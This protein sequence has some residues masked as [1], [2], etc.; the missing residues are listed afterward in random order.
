M[1]VAALGSRV[2]V[3]RR[4]GFVRFGVKEVDHPHARMM[5]DTFHANI[6]EKDPAAA[7]ERLGGRT[8]SV[9]VPGQGN[10][11]D[12]ED[13]VERDLARGALGEQNQL[14]HHEAAADRDARQTV[15]LLYTYL[16]LACP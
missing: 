5:Y 7:I 13:L 16:L 15:W 4:L 11:A 1:R 12:R 9:M 8:E 6:E 2:G 3:R 14:L 10:E